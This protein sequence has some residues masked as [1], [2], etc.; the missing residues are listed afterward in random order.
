MP[1]YARGAV[2]EPVASRQPR[3]RAGRRTRAPCVR[4]SA[5]ATSRAQLPRVHVGLARLRVHRHD[6]AGLVAGSRPRMSTTGFVIWRSP[7]V[8]LDACRRTR[9]RCPTASCLLAPRL[10]EERDAQV[11]RA[12]EDLDLDERAALAR[13]P[14]R[15]PSSP[16]RRRSPPRRRRASA[17]S[18]P[19]ACGRGSGA[20]SA[21]SRSSTLV[22]PML[23]EP[24]GERV[25]DGLQLGDAA[26]VE[27]AQRQ[28]GALGHCAPPTRR[29]RGT[30]TAAGRPRAPRPRRA[31]AASPRCSRSCRRRSVAAS[32]P[33]ST[34]TSSL[35][36]STSSSQQRDRGV[37]RR[38]R[39]RADAV[40]RD[41]DP[42]ALL[43]RR[44]TSAV[45][46]AHGLRDL[47]GAARG[48]P[49]RPSRRRSRRGRRRGRRRRARRAPPRSPCVGTTPTAPLGERVDL[50]RHRDDVLVVR[51]HDRPSRRG[52]RSTA[53]R[54]CAV[55]GF[56]D[57]P[58][59]TTS[60][61]PRLWSSRRTPSPTPTATT[62][63]ATRS[64]D[65]AGRRRRRRPRR[66]PTAPPRPARG[67][68]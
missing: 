68:R 27:L 5:S 21:A 66:A 52:T 14:A 30:G 10:V 8:V 42:V 6:H 44:R 62:P 49:P 41:R 40:A 23:G 56:I 43:D 26:L 65:G 4:S 1:Q 45:A 17:I 36:S 50:L 37:E 15:R 12:V 9:P 28:A 20:G 33:T 60:C 54:I 46:V 29:R 55:D 35:S 64:P 34:V 48:R 51:Q 11:R 32:A 57:C 24:L 19:L 47:A 3:R 63:V 58:P 25:A 67:G 53:S 59:A 22:I 31:G 13:A 7:A 39:R 38:R 18:G 2:D 61:T 16:R